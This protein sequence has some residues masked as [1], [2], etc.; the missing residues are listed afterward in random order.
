MSFRSVS[1]TITAGGK[2]ERPKIHRRFCAI[3]CVKVARFTGY[4]VHDFKQIGINEYTAGAGIGWHRDKQEFGDVMGISVLS[5]ANMGFRKPSDEGWAR[6]SHVLEPRSVYVLSGEVRQVWE[7]SIP[8]VTSLRYS[9][10]F[11]TLAS[12]PA[13]G[14]VSH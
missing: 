3:F 1:A 2:S 11:R 4:E 7:H 9:L 8:P 5:S 12:F 13:R 14:A 6:R 10:T